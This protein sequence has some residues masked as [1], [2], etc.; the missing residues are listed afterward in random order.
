MTDDFG[1]TAPADGAPTAGPR[2]DVAPTAGPQADGDL[3][4]ED[5]R[6]A[7]IVGEGEL[8]SSKVLD[9]SILYAF[10]Q[11]SEKLCQSQGFNPFLVLI[12]GEEL[13]IEEQ[14]AESEADSYASARRTIFQMDKICASYIFCYDGYVT[15]ED[16]D[17][18]AL[19]VEYASREDEAAQVIVRLYHEHDGHYH[20]DDGLY[21]VGDAPS[22]FVDGDGEAAVEDGTE[23]AESDIDAADADEADGDAA[24]GAEASDD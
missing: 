9:R 12:K 23:G 21:A 2:A 3:D 1:L 4:V 13:F 11:G 20:F 14:P 5:L 22:L 15:L 17:S 18:D 19:V 24:V 8:D 16:G 7:G 10:E 6:F